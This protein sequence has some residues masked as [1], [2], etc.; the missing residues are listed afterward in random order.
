MPISS[1][2][3]LLLGLLAAQTGVADD[4]H[5]LFERAVVVAAV[6]LPA[7]RRHIGELI[8]LDEVPDAELG[9]VNAQLVGHYVR[10]ALHRIY[11]FGDPERAPVGDS[12][13]RLVGINAVHFDERFFEVV[14]ACADMEQT[15]RELGRIGGRVGVAVVGYGLDS[16]GFH[17]PVLAGG[18]FSRDVVVASEGVCNEVLHAV[19]DPLHG[20]AG[21]E[22]SGDGQHV[23][24]VDRHLTAEAAAD[25]RGYDP[26]LVLGQTQ[27]P[28]YQGQ[29]G[30]DNVRGLGG[31][32][33]GQLFLDRV[34]LGHTAARLDR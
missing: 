24:G 29:D 26:N 20:M 32:P 27:V 4:L 21:E 15:S 12:S 33:H 5:R 7:Q 13:G 34:P 16:H 10:H 25:I 9:R 3:G 18:H 17:L 11:R 23:A 22:G 31:H 1:P 6:V 8:R 14:G 28:G 2:W 30:A 19:L